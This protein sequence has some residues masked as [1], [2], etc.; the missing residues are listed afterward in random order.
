MKI[1]L[2]ED[3]REV[4]RHVA[5]GL[6]SRGYE[7]DVAGDGEAGLTRAQSNVHDVIIMDRMLPVLDGLSIVRRLREQHISTP[8]LYL[9]TMD[10]IEDRVAGLEA[11][12]DDYLVKPFAFEELLARVRAL[13]RRPSQTQE[14][15]TRLAV[16]DIELNLLTRTVTRA[17]KEIELFPQEFKLLEHLM[18]QAGQV[19]TRAMLLEKVW[20]VHFAVNTS[21]VESHMSRLRSKLGPD[22]GELIQTVRGAGYMFRAI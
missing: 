1:L 15:K 6:E 20:D 12:G 9:T 5:G 21:V 14:D 4:A 16:G 2:V 13:A 7:V 11:G 18:R 22:G 17:G 10:A 19:V 3:D 8:V